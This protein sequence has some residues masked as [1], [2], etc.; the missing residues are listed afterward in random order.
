MMTFQ[1]QLKL[2]HSIGG[3]FPKGYFDS[4]TTKQTNYLRKL[5]REHIL[6]SKWVRAIEQCSL[7]DLRILWEVW[8]SP[9]NS[10]AKGKSTFHN[11]NHSLE[12]AD[13]EQID[14]GLRALIYCCLEKHHKKL[15]IVEFEQT[16]LEYN[17]RLI[18]RFQ[19]AKRAIQQYHDKK[20]D[21]FLRRLMDNAFAWIYASGSGLAK[22]ASAAIFFISFGIMPPAWVGVFCLIALSLV[23]NLNQFQRGKALRNV[24]MALG[25]L[26]VLSA[27]A[28]AIFVF[29]ALPWFYLTFALLIGYVGSLSSSQVVKNIFA[30]F[31]KNASIK[32]FWHDLV[33]KKDNVPLNWKESLLI[34][35]LAVP[36][37]TIGSVIFAFV[38]YQS[39]AYFFVNVPILAG[40]FAMP[41]VPWILFG[42]ALITSLIS[43][44]T[45]FRFVK[46]KFIYLASL[47]FNKL[48]SW[49]SG[50]INQY[51]N[52]LKQN[53]MTTVL[54]SAFAAFLASISVLYVIVGAKVASLAFMRFCGIAMS[55]VNQW[56]GFVTALVFIAPTSLMFA[57]EAKSRLYQLAL[58][59]GQYLKNL[60]SFRGNR[61][62][63]DE[64]SRIKVDLR[65]A[66]RG[67][68]IINRSKSTF[69]VVL[70]AIGKGA[71]SFNPHTP[72]ESIPYIVISTVNAFSAGLLGLQKSYAQ[73]DISQD[74]ACIEALTVNKKGP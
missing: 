13:R 36:L 50:A 70:N 58:E 21:S 19:K 61:K 69:N 2:A 12:R 39:L 16:H 5:V 31:R 23:F 28:A 47:D 46:D 51:W 55:Q 14:A 68:T 24:L 22:G 1:E 43:V 7:D 11:Y 71:L 63:K 40:F 17:S 52:S 73:R 29:P 8:R 53:P 38:S 45:T 25:S 41:A 56:A 65:D 3:R 33:Y 9:R 44:V 32:R 30:D 54:K 35:G 59:C 37:S 4:D 18:E 27:V 72:S 66:E 67:Y 10:K 60:I 74:C 26:I 34:Y 49:C 42:I 62:S 48:G 20:K 64:N 6:K 15:A 57:V